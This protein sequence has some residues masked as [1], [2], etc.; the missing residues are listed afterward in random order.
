MTFVTSDELSRLGMHLGVLA[1]T[2]SQ[3]PRELRAVHIRRAER[4]LLLLEE[5]GRSTIPSQARQWLQAKDAYTVLS[6]RLTAVEALQSDMWR[7]QNE[8]DDLT[9]T[10]RLW[11]VL[12]DVERQ[13]F[14]LNHQRSKQFIDQNLAHAESHILHKYARYKTLNRLLPYADNA[15]HLCDAIFHFQNRDRYEENIQRIEQRR[16]NALERMASVKR[17]FNLALFLCLLIVSIPLC[18]PVAFSLWNRK[19]EIE[20]QLANM[21]ELRRREERRLQIADEGVIAAEE[22]KDIL[23]EA[24]LETVRRTLEELRELRSEF[25][26]AEKNPSVTAGLVSFVDLYKPRLK[27]L[28]GSLPDDMASTFSWFKQEVDRLLNVEAER[29][30]LVARLQESND[31]LSRLMKGHNEVILRDSFARVKAIIDENFSIDIDYDYKVDLAK[32]IVK[33]PDLLRD[34]RVMLSQ[35]SYGQI[36]DLGLWREIHRWML[37]LESNFQAMS[38]EMQLTHVQHENNQDE[39]ESVAT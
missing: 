5:F 29:A 34:M 21:A 22:I 10:L 19:R 7:L 27:E 17:G 6:K 32:N 25:Q 28:F 35:I 24:P 4:S 3:D 36:V 16:E 2:S 39:L 26:R 33:L 20:N 38:L 1:V 30:A 13:K 9:N 31:K 8:V 23:G 18:A 15:E 12:Q 11:N 14:L 37:T